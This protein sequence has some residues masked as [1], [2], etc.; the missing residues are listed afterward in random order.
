[1]GAGSGAGGLGTPP[2]RPACSSYPQSTGKR[3]YHKLMTNASQS[4]ARADPSA[5]T[6]TNPEFL[7]RTTSREY[8]GAATRRPIPA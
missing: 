4:F 7:F 2:P 5:T 8:N 3:V 1:M 6:M